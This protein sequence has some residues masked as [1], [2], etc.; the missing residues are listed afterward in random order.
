MT[1]QQQENRGISRR[2][3][4]V[5]S[6]LGTLA[7]GM[8]GRTASGAEHLNQVLN[9]NDVHPFTINMPD[10]ALIDLKSRL[11]N[12]RW[13]DK[14]TVADSSQGLQLEKLKS[15]VSYW[16]SD[17]NWRTIERRLNALP[18]YVTRIEGLTIHFIH[19]R[20]RHPNAL[21]LILTH[22]WPGSI[23]EFMKV[24]APLTDPVAHGG[25]AAEAFDLIIPSIPGY[26]FSQRPTDTGWKPDRVAAMWDTLV[27]R[28]G[29]R[30]YVSQGGDHGSV[31][32]TALGRLAPSGLLGIHLTMPATVPGDLI[33]AI[34][35]GLPA[36]H[37][38]SAPEQRAFDKLSHF[39]TRN[40]AYGAMMVTRPQTIG[41]ALNDSPTG[42]AAWSYDKIAQWTDS[43][44]E[45]ERVL[46]RDEILDDLSLYWLTDTSTSAARFYW[47]NNNN[48]FSSATQKTHDVK[49]PVAISVFPGEIYQAPE[50]WSQAAFP[51]LNYYHSVAKGGHFAAWEQPALFSE[52]MRNAFRRLRS[53]T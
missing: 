24:I 13:P 9:D 10:S 4:I 21:P 22:G 19:V 26:G 12:T 6:A 31:I 40:S 8:M 53:R 25:S 7:L 46:S 37:P 49:V 1:M 33:P 3:L 51:T 38:L 32:S 44:G 30:E 18:Q 5:G 35:E 29:Y 50:S 52:E 28:L 16:A 11:L 2:K 42:M 45:P 36:P 14:E 20:S 23:L 41:Y 43:N 47:E 39:F 34:N 15:L 27:K 48:N 17:Y